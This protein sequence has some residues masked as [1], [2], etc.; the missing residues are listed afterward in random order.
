MTDEPVIVV[1][2]GV[3]GSCIAAS[4]A[5]RGL[6]VLV[7]S[8][9]PATDVG[10]AAASAGILAPGHVGPL[11][12]PRVLADGIRHVLGRPPAVRLPH[13]TAELVWLGRLVSGAFGAPRRAR[14]EGI[15]ALAERSAALH[16]Q[17]AERGVSTT[18]R[19][20]GAV[21]VGVAGVAAGHLEPELD[22]ALT[23]RLDDD[24]A[25]VDP[26]RFVAEMRG[27]A[28]RLGARFLFDTRAVAVTGRPDTVR[29]LATD[30][31]E[32]AASRVV[33]AT[34]AVPSRLAGASGPG[35]VLPGRGH[36]VDVTGG[37]VLRRPVRL[38]GRRV[39]IT[40]LPGRTRVCGYLDLGTGR[41]RHDP[42]TDLIRTAATAVPALRE[43]TV[44]RTS[45]GD[46]PC[47]ATGL[48]FIGPDPARRG[49]WHAAGHGMWGLILGPV[50][51]EL[52]AD[53]VQAA[54]QPGG[55]G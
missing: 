3:V 15:H 38:V 50:T 13:R 12:T 26:V 4:L 29:G 40:P 14:R 5:A 44:V 24:E 39:V 53:S 47:L 10:C 35:H 6:P 54:P 52:I 42:T 25:V 9:G 31:G 18:W 30:R 27:E 32:L 34:G 37:P 22:P 55:S 21:E 36:A 45:T 16:A 20:T 1:G 19:R 48:P 7:V 51:G 23:G 2:A 28:E 43:A 49:L 17:L 11:A 33:L 8:A 41:P 46:R